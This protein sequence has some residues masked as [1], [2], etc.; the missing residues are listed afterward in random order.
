MKYLIKIVFILLMFNLISCFKEDE[1]DEKEKDSCKDVHCESYEMCAKGVC[2]LL[3][4]KCETNID[5]E[6]TEICNSEHNCISKTCDENQTDEQTCGFN[7]NGTQ[8]LKCVNNEWINDGDCVDVDF[9]V[10]ETIETVKCGYSDLG[11]FQRECQ[12]GRWSLGDFCNFNVVDE[13]FDI[14]DIITDFTV[15]NNVTYYAKTV[16][17]NPGRMENKDVIIYKADS[18]SVN[19]VSI[20]STADEYDAKIFVD[21]EGNIY[22]TGTTTGSFGEYPNNGLN[23]IF[24]SKFNNNLEQQWIIVYGNSGNEFATD[25]HVFENKIFVS[26]NI[27]GE[28]D[29]DGIILKYDLNGYYIRE[30]FYENFD[31]NDFVNAIDVDN[32]GNL[33]TTGEIKIS[34]TT[35]KISITKFNIFL[36]KEWTKEYGDSG[37][38]TANDIKFFAGNLYISGNTTSPD[39]FGNVNSGL[40]DAFIMI[41]DN[42]HNITAKLIGSENDDYANKLFINTYGDIYIYGNTNGSLYENSSMGGSDVFFAKYNFN[43]DLINKL[44]FGSVDINGKNTDLNSGFV[45]HDNNLYLSGNTNSYFTTENTTNDTNIFFAKYDED[46]ICN[47]GEERFVICETDNT[48]IQKIA[49]DENVWK[50]V[51]ECIPVPCNPEYGKVTKCGLND[52][53]YQNYIC[54]NDMWILSGQCNDP[55]SCTDGETRD[56]VC[57]TNGTQSYICNFG[58]WEQSGSCS[59]DI[60]QYGDVSGDIYAVKHKKVNNF[61]Y[62]LGYAFNNFQSFTNSGN[63]NGTCDILVIKTDDSGNIITSNLIGTSSNDTPYDMAIDDN[64]NIY[65]T[66]STLEQLPF[67]ETSLGE[68]DAFI[69]KYNSDLVIQWIKQYGTNVKDNGKGIII[70]DGYIYLTGTTE[71]SMAQGREMAQDIF[72]MKLDMEGN[73]FL[74]YQLGSNNNEYPVAITEHNNYLYITGESHGKF[75]NPVMGLAFSGFIIKID[76]NFQTPFFKQFQASTSIYSRDIAVDSLG[77]VFITGTLVGDWEGISGST[78]NDLFVAKFDNNL[79]YIKHYLSNE[80]YISDSANSIVIDENDK[81]HIFGEL[82]TTGNYDSWY[83]KQDNDLNILEQFFITGINNT[84]TESSKDINIFDNKIYMLGSTSGTFDSNDTNTKEKLFLYY[85]DL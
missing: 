28:V 69:I 78:G 36:E 75:D 79:S 35:S 42:V 26:G 19:N 70:K 46:M 5:C 44:Q 52:R 38:N 24:I 57:G 8:K 81:I 54:E 12:N 49:C 17:V 21:E 34:E 1:K 73:Q 47:Q 62:I 50:Y 67:A 22:V 55:D 80:S 68:E 48:L 23:D 43:L 15:K 6:T 82:I 30:Q 18:N 13:S 10:N 53:G 41:V 25:I 85:K 64:G 74:V 66:G 58:Q 71:G 56:E 7:G 29:I 51:T 45:W 84:A 9:C 33:Y 27:D 63:N 20:S 83:L 60:K 77:N 14:N 32:E 39:F 31:F 4:N 65:V 61:N 11:E 3:P 72:I 16:V 76:L 2:I 40:N 59:Q 37:I